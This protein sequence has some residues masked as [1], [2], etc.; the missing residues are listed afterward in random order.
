[1]MHGPMNVKLASKMFK[2]LLQR[3]FLT[4]N[5]LPV[6]FAQSRNTPQVVYIQEKFV[7]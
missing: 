7:V 6:S 4:F 1:M 2:I 5:E 3:Y